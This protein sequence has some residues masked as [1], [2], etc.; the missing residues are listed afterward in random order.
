[1]ETSA[2]SL[3]HLQARNIH[4]LIRSPGKPTCEIFISLGTE[5]KY[6]NDFEQQEA[7]QDKK[8]IQHLLI[9]QDKHFD[10][11]DKSDRARAKYTDDL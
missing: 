4:R 7:V 3:K 10:A 5:E 9:Q 11:Y 8:G 1:M 6:S 2:A